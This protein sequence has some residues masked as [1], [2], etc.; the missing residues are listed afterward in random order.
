MLHQLFKT[1]SQTL[2]E[3]TKHS[4]DL[5]TEWKDQGF[6][7]STAKYTVEKSALLLVCTS[8]LIKQKCL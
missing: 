4:E 1:E 7:S 3:K 6:L 8:H 5:R 2:K